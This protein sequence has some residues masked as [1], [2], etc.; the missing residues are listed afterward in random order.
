EIVE[1]ERAHELGS[2]A[3][4]RQELFA[5]EPADFANARQVAAQIVPAKPE[6]RPGTLP[7]AASLGEEAPRDFILLARGRF[8]VA[9]DLPAPH[10]KAPDLAAIVAKPMARRQGA[11]PEIEVGAD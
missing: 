2:A 10:A 3:A 9:R 1:D 8:H 7:F 11:R 4:A 6:L 5:R